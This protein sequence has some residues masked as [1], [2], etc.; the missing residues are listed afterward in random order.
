VAEAAEERPSGCQCFSFPG[1]E[2]PPWR[3]EYEALRRQRIQR[4]ALLIQGEPLKAFPSLFPDHRLHRLKCTGSQTP[5]GVLVE[6]GAPH[7][8]SGLSVRQWEA[9]CVPMAKFE[10]V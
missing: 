1:P 3:A 6:M 2:R 4:N 10:A 5:G 7:S 8:V 9:V